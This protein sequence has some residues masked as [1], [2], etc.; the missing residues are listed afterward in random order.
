MDPDYEGGITKVTRDTR[1]NGVS[2]VNHVT[3]SIVNLS[4]Y[5]SLSWVGRRWIG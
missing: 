2:D 1:G 5:R 3:G 4:D